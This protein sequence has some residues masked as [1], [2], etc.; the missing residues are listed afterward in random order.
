MVKLR[1]VIKILLVACA[2]DLRDGA[3]QS[4][5]DSQLVVSDRQIRLRYNARAYRARLRLDFVPVVMYR[6]NFL[7]CWGTHLR[8]NIGPRNDLTRKK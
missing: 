2:L 5:Y 8:R 6:A 7:S 4:T 3:T 1:V